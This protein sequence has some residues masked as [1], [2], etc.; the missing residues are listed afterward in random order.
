MSAM[1]RRAI[2]FADSA[3]ATL[4]VEWEFALV[5]KTSR[6][7]VNAASEL[8]D[9]VSEHH[10][11]QP[12]LH[13]EL[14]RNTVE[15]TTGVCRTTSE[16]IDQLAEMIAM[17]RPVADELGVDLYCAGTHPFAEWSH[18][19]LTPGHR[20]EEL[21]ARTQW[22]GRQMLI[23]GVHVHVGV[24]REHVM[25]IVSSLLTWFPHLQALSASSPDLGRHRHRVRQQ[26]RDDVPAAADRRPA[27]PLRDL[28][29]LRVLRRR[30]ADDR[31]HRRGRRDPL[32]HP[33]GASSWAPSRS[34]CATASPP[35]TR[36]AR[37][38]PSPTASSSTSPTGSTGARRC[39]ACRR[40]TCRR[41]SGGPRATAS[42]RGSSSTTPP[43]SACCSTTSTTC[44][45]TSSRS[46]ERLGC[47]AE[48][49]LVR[50]IPRRG[51]SYQRQREV[52]TSR[53]R[54][55]GG[56]G[57]LGGQRARVR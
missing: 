53:A 31:R 45:P 12:R 28:G 49:D 27:V 43:T 37:S 34:A 46:P 4:G 11:E 26:P 35:S 52:A 17:V 42:T 23:W 19:L 54:R 30:P 21:I 18:Q 29:R 44:S 32:G 13:K 25:P 14:L 55:P 8:F 22:W 33:P 3:P 36:C 10:G 1:A 41:T 16:A 39:R 20:Y 47:E 15:L 48:L 57:R 2:E 9:L 56:R 7:L 51:A 5:D 50:V 38:W 6:D 40:G 24:R